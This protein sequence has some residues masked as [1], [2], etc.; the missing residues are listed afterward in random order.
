[1]KEI[2][3]LVR[4]EFIQFSRDPRLVF[5]ILAAPIIQ[6]VLL[7]YAAVLDVRN[8]PMAVCDLDRTRESRAYVEAMVNSGYFRISS[9]VGEMD[10][11]DRLIDDGTAA[12]AVIIPRGFGDDVLGYR[13]ASVEVIVDGSESQTATIGINAASA[14][15]TRFSGQIL[16]RILSERGGP[17]FEPVMIDPEIRVWYNP[18]LKSRNFFVPGVLALVLMMMTMLVTAMA[19]VREKETGTMEQLMVS[20]IRPYQLLAGKIV[21]STAVGLAD[22]VLVLAS[23]RWL[24]WVPLKGSVPL[25][26]LMI[27]AFI[28]TTLGLGLFIST[29]SQNQQQAMFTSVFFILPMILLG[30]FVFPIAN[31]P[32]FFQWLTYG[33]PIRYFF[34]I[35]RG[36]FL[37]GVGWAELQDETA[38]LLVIGVV[39]FGLSLLRFRKKLG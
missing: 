34:T 32:R 13:Q 22:A 15:S 4:K 23:A 19:V 37:K 5:I 9:H 35:V 17:G 11:I 28:L 2:L 14:V 31:M 38:A 16:R 24:L 27:L 36:I 12:M 39:V 10:L 8:L 21:P 33:I 30:G 6:L 18:A 1:L 29:I 3:A 7:G 20:P 26:F 25:L